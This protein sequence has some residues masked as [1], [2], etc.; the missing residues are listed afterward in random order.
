MDLKLDFF[1][2]NFPKLH[3]TKYVKA[4]S[5]SLKQVVPIIQ[6]QVLHSMGCYE[7]NSDD[8]DDDDGKDEC[9]P[10][11]DCS[12][13][14]LT[15]LYQPDDEFPTQKFI[16]DFYYTDVNEKVSNVFFFQM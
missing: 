12:E 9:N 11:I 14:D 5:F 3:E 7:L 6:E 8:D 4:V 13:D 16:A 2:R 1:K 15:E 10:Q